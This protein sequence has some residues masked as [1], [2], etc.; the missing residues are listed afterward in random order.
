MQPVRGADLHHRIDR[1]IEELALAKPGAGEELDR[2]PRESGAGRERV[3]P[4]RR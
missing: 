2:Q 1:E 4:A 3:G